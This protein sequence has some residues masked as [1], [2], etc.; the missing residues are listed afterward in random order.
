MST[1]APV[2]A[3]RSAASL[4]LSSTLCPANSPPV[5]CMIWLTT[6]RWAGTFSLRSDCN[7]R[8]L[9][10]M[11]RTVGMVTITNSVVSSLRKRSFTSLSCALSASSFATA[12]SCSW[13][14]TPNRPLTASVAEVSFCRSRTILP[15]EASRKSGSESRRRVCPVGAVSK[16]MRVNLAYLSSL[17]NCTTLAIAMA[18]SRPGGG[19]SRSS[20]SLRSPSWSAKPPSPTL[21]I[22]FFAPAPMSLVLANAANSALAWS[23]STSIAYSIISV[24]STATGIPPVTSCA[25]ESVRECAGSVLTSKVGCPLMANFT[26]SEEDSEV[27][28]TPP[29]PPTM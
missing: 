14:S 25:S 3:S 13:L 28:P 20:P 1:P 24:P 10:E 4:A 23:G 21:D 15:M 16:T 8:L 5:T 12:S 26:A 19:V 27:L 18:S 11:P 9:S 29:L 22:K 7:R 2:I 6:R 17:M